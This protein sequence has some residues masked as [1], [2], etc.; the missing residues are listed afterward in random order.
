MINSGT[1]SSDISITGWSVLFSFSPPFFPVFQFIP[2]KMAQMRNA[3]VRNRL[4][5]R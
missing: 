3:P 2:S 1:D 4:K 5:G